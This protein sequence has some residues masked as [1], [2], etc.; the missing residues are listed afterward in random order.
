[1]Q[2]FSAPTAKAR[3][4][5]LAQSTP[6]MLASLWHRLARASHAGTACFVSHITFC[7]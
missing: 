7:P 4:R 6:I 3:G 5:S 1:M 2:R